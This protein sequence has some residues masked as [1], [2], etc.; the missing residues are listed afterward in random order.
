MFVDQA[1]EHVVQIGLGLALLVVAVLATV[2]AV[3]LIAVR[4]CQTVT[5]RAVL[6]A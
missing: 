6:G 1:L 4:R 3:S 5:G 2:A